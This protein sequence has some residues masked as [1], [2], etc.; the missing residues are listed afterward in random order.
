MIYQNC[1][2]K[3][4]DEFED[5]D[6]CFV[7]DGVWFGLWSERRSTAFENVRGEG[8]AVF[9]QQRHRTNDTGLAEE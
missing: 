1:W 4:W 6:F 9:L 8:L 2:K 3:P 5:A 7:V